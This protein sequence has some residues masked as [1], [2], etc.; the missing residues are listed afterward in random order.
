MQNQFIHHVFFW[1]KNPESAADRAQFIA[2]LRKLSTVET[3]RATHI[4]TPAATDRAVIDSSYDV[5]WF[6]VFDNLADQEIY[7]N[8]P[9]HL[10]FIEKNNHLWTKVLVFDSESA[11]SV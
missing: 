10:D 5:S 3:L 9:I 8:H 11:F 2:A 4:G 7:Q 1:L 6:N